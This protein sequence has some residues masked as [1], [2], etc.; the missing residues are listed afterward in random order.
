MRIRRKH[1]YA[2]FVTFEEKQISKIINLNTINYKFYQI[3]IE[4]R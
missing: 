2:N 1:Q 4:L 3:L